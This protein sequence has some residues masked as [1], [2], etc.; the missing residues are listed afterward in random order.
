[1]SSVKH[2]NLVCLLHS[3]SKNDRQ[4][5]TLSQLLTLS[6]AVCRCSTNF[7]VG[8][9]SNGSICDLQRMYLW[10]V[11]ILAQ[12][13]EIFS[14]DGALS[15]KAE[16]LLVQSVPIPVG[17]ALAHLHMHSISNHQLQA[18][19]GCTNSV[20]WNISARSTIRRKLL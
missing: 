5:T 19:T 9:L 1:M 20:T 6:L 4:K 17:C 11:W 7:F 8:F 10:Q 3:P 2:L 16:G 13:V 12:L 15:Q 18:K 14:N